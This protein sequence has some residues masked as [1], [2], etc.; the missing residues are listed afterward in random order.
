M[1]MGIAQ[2]AREAVRNLDPARRAEVL[3]EVRRRHRNLAGEP[4]DSPAVIGAM[5][6][7]LNPQPNSVTSRTHLKPGEVRIQPV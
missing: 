4:D 1:G 3:A 7:I 6:R 5:Y 2:R